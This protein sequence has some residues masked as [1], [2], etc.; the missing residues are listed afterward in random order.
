MSLFR[1]E[2][3][4]T[5]AAASHA[6][7]GLKKVLGPFDLILMGRGALTAGPALSKSIV[8]AAL[9]RGFAALCFAEFASSVPVAGSIYT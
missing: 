1:T 5:M 4:T 8:I 7:E 3:L 9:V 2:D 6:P